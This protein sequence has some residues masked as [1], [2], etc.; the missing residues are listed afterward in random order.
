MTAIARRRRQR[1]TWALICGL[2]GASMLPSGLVLATNSLL[3][4][5]DGNSVDVGNLTRVPSTPAALLA[6][7][8]GRPLDYLVPDRVIEIIR[9]RGLYGLRVG[10]QL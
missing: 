6:V 4:S 1:T 10:A 8:D 5:T 7:V 9:K 2:V 3:H